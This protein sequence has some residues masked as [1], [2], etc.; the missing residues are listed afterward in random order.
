MK[1]AYLENRIVPVLRVLEEQSAAETVEITEFYV[2]TCGSRSWSSIVQEDHTR[3]EGRYTMGQTWGGVDYHC[4]FKQRVILPA[5]FAGK[6]VYCRVR[7]G[8]TDIW[9]YDNPQFLAFVDG[10]LICGLDVNHTEFCV[11]PEVPEGECSIELA[12]YAYCSTTRNDLFLDVSLML[13]QED[14]R[15]LAF[16][17]DIPYKTLCLLSPEEPEY[18]RLSHILHS[19]LNLLDLRVPGSEAFL[20]SVMAARASLA[21]ELYMAAPVV[22]SAQGQAVQHCIGHTHIDIAWL[23]T[24]EQTREKV[25]RSF[26]TVLHLMEQ[27][28]EYKFMSSQPQL[29]AFVKEDAPGLYAKIKDRVAEGRWEVEG[30]MWLE[31]D[32]TISS[33]ESLVRHILYGKE[34]I[35]RE[36]G[37]DSKVLWLPDVFGYCAALPQIMKKSGLDYFMTTKINWNDTN[38]LPHDTLMWQGIDGT[39]VLSYFITTKDYDPLYELS[40]HPVFSTT[41]NGTLEPNQVKGGWQRYRDKEI[42]SGILQCYGNGDGGGGPTAEMLENARRMQAGLPGLPRVEHTFVLDFFQGLEKQVKDNPRLPRWVGEL[43]LEYHRGT[44]TSMAANKRWNRRCEGLLADAELLASL[45]ALCLPESRTYPA[46]AL[47]QAWQL[48]LLNQFH[49]ILPGTAIAQVYEVSEKQYEE[50]EQ[51][52]SALIRES[53]ESL[54]EHG[55]KGQITV[56]NTLS[57]KRAELV[58]LPSVPEGIAVFQKGSRLPSCRTSDGVLHFLAEELPAMGGCTY[59][60]RSSGDI[61]SSL[62]PVLEQ[63]GNRLITPHYEITLDDSGFMVSILDKAHDRE[64]VAAGARANEL[65]VF[66]DRPREYDAWNIDAHFEEQMWVM[67]GLEQSEIAENNPLF[68]VL[69][70]K[71]RFL[72]SILEQDIV[73]YRHTRRIDFRTAVQWENEHLLVKAAFPTT[74][75]TAKAVYDI[76]FGNVERPTHRNTS[77]DAARFEVSA[78]KW[79]DLSENGY[80]ISLMNDCKYGYDICGSIMRLTLLKSATYP[81]PGADKGLH[82]FTYSLFPH[83]GD[84]RQG[85]VVQEAESLNRPV[86]TVAGS[87]QHTAAAV[88]S[89]LVSCS[90]PN[91]NIGTVK[92]A[93][94]GKGFVIRMFE[95]YGKRTRAAFTLN[96]PGLYSIEECD[97][98]EQPVR[99]LS[100]KDGNVQLELKPYEII[101]LLAKTR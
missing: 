35:R 38:S 101:T 33:G 32:C 87:L 16:D 12:F 78:H 83:S 51:T 79:A 26:S 14:V 98:L 91:I 56:F 69:R 55:E 68:A 86:C 52:A 77:W 41:Y 99:S 30:G 39:E 45:A 5:A 8:K 11:L 10:E 53:L 20:D 57:W 90:E 1:P 74:M 22:S 27:Y 36:F 46:E 94:S 76:Q 58:A 66:A 15:G 100:L 4:C 64:L 67:D 6:P 29:Y 81:N 43:Y 28:P 3:W 75:M 19:A 9:N 63:V 50:V 7:T 65:Q 82:R 92:A 25:I 13:R 40:A 97:L 72:S 48:V 2:K 31:A 34:F 60:L 21:R 61:P 54:C 42:N 47:R 62:P 93:E 84:F 37:R 70:Q 85:G 18:H 59:D 71:R 88:T 95:F 89:G 24:V 80:G 73:F 23:W 96:L 17:L 44:Y 49:D